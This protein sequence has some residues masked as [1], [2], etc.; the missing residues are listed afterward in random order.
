MI[1]WSTENIKWRTLITY[2]SN[3]LGFIDGQTLLKTSWWIDMYVW[4]CVRV[5]IFV[6]V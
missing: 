6:Y 2:N 3:I 5:R 1:V 4:L